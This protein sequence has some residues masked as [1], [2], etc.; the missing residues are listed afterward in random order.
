MEKFDNN[1]FAVSFRSVIDFMITILLWTY[2]TIGFLAFFSIPYIK[3]F[4]FSKNREISFQRLN[5]KFYRGFFVLV[6]ILIPQHKWHIGSDV[7]GIRS[8]VIVCNHV[9]YLDPLLLISLFEKHKTI[10]KNSFFKVPIFG[11]MLILS[12]YIPSTFEGKW[13]ELMIPRIEAVKDYLADG[14]NV[15]IFPEGTRSRDGN[16]GSFHKGAFK[17]ARL[18]NAPIRV[19]FIR[20]TN[21]LFRPGRFLFNTSVS[22]TITVELLNTVDPDYRSDTFSISG[23][24]S[25]VRSLLEAQVEKYLTG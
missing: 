20:N 22:N 17:I 16:I 4:L 5:H 11:R 10:V 18:C 23:L 15:F 21:M 7:P 1:I 19:L 14:G 12:G 9:S 24:I 2:F 25:H 6:R 3:A 8:S 13:S